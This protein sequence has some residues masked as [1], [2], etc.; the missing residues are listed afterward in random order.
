MQIGGF[1]ILSSSV[2][3]S[4]RSCGVQAL[5]TILLGR[6]CFL[7]TDLSRI[8]AYLGFSQ[9]YMLIWDLLEDIQSIT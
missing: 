8:Y 3:M 6:K 5:R 4:P 9:E 1:I 2:A 7:N